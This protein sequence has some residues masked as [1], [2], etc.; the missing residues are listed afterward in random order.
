M[1]LFAL[2]LAPQL[3]RCA[4]GG[5]LAA[6][7]T[8]ASARPDTRRLWTYAQ[9]Q[10][11]FSARNFRQMAPFARRLRA[12]LPVNVVVL[13]SSIASS[14]AGAFHASPSALAAAVPAAVLWRAASTECP[15][16]SGAAVQAG[17]LRQLAKV[18][19]ALM[20]VGWVGQLSAYVVRLA[21]VR[22]EGLDAAGYYQAAYAISG[23]LP[24][25]V[26]AAMGADFFPRI[27]A[28]KNEEE[29]CLLTEKQIQAALLLGAPLII[30]ITTLGRPA[31]S[32]LYP[33]KFTQ[34]L[35]LLQWMAWGVFLRL[36]TWPMGFCLLARGSGRQ[37][38]VIESS[39]ALIA[40]ALPY[41]LLPRYGL[42]SAAAAFLISNAAYGVIICCYLV[43]KYR[44]R[45]GMRTL[46]WASVAAL[47]TLASQWWGMQFDGSVLAVLP[48]FMAAIIC[49]WAYRRELETT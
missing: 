8:Y 19:G 45:F 46:S 27:S 3:A 24:G 20:I 18:G 6:R 10:D 33:D 16:C 37:L 40:A 34:A 2:L 28:A 49:A 31:L 11:A 7:W 32:M 5:D 35:P 23:S 13:G 42:V 1:L 4:A 39:A 41:V 36:I 21:I 12:G 38:V 22:Q 48:V 29:A 9:L 17:D 25:F 26:F 30:A 15:A 43:V 47:F 44:Y 14:Y